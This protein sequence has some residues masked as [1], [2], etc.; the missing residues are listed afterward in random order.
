ML[1]L[2]AN[3]TP[4]SDFNQSPRNMYQCQ[5]GKQTMGVP[6][7][8]FPHRS[9]TKL[10]RFNTPQT[11][12]V[13]TQTYRKYDLD[14][15]PTGTNAV[16]A[17]IAYT[18]YDM[19][20]AMI[21]N[22]SSYERG[23]GSASLYTTY[24]V[25]LEEKRTRGAPIIH[26]FS[27]TDPVTKEM[28]A[29]NLDEDGL[30]GVGLLLNF[31]DP[32]YTI[33]ND[34]TGQVEIHRHKNI[35]SAVVDNVRL[36]A[37]ADGE[38][39]K[40]TITL[41]Y[42]RNPVI[43]DK[44]SSRHGQKG[45]LSFLWPDENMPFAES[46]IRP[47]IIINPHAF[48][49]RMTIGMLVESMAGKS[50]AVHGHFQDATPFRFDEQQRAVDFFG[51]ELVAAGFHRYGNE[52]MYSGITGTELHA[53]IFIGV[54]YYQRL[55]HMV[56]DKF[57]VRS[58]GPVNQITRQPVKGRKREGGIRFGEMERDSLLAH[59]TAF[60]LY[61][62]LFRCSD[63]DLAQVCTKC[64]SFAGVHIVPQISFRRDPS[65]PQ[66]E[67]PKYTCR[68]CGRSDHI[69]SV[70]MPFVFKYLVAELAAMNVKVGLSVKPV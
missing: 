46:G 38:A 34:L 2:V 3:L 68:Q 51:E 26:H 6:V 48:P 18:G 10:Y 70:T 32:L 8:S 59:G 17:V 45:V 55:R 58:T 1:S 40:A 27:N 21:I 36:I 33:V 25:D 43:G 16:V 39:Q 15:Y 69:S 61:D 14:M 19:E 29:D 65:A 53:H 37:S 66:L 63:D 9:D 30:P 5:M 60:M 20:D 12:L 11:P 62:R 44:S 49:S 67:A 13:A 7:H 31:N 24:E 42:N 57:Q 4:F 23:Y 52:P 47:D 50:G 56:S 28:V 41:R 35:D 64:D 54:V 22:K